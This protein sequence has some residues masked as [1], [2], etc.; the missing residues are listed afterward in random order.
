MKNINENK[1]E[2]TKTNENETIDYDEYF[3]KLKKIW[4]CR[5]S[6]YFVKRRTN[7]MCTRIL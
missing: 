2:T 3:K 5:Y 7:Q 4:I 6:K 1:N